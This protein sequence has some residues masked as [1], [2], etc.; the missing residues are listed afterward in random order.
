MRNA[1][2]IAKMANKFDGIHDP[3][4]PFKCQF[5]SF[6][7][8]KRDMDEIWDIIRDRSLTDGD[9]KKKLRAACAQLGG[10]TMCFMAD[11]L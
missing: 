8:M 3:E 10:Q 2:V 9:R 11:L 7:L 6:A 4:D 5:H 1:D